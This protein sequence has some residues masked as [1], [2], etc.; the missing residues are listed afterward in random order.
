METREERKSWGKKTN[1][2]KPGN[3]KRKLKKVWGRRAG[4]SQGES[5]DKMSPWVGAGESEENN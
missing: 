5:H 1:F 3:K 4:N 2:T